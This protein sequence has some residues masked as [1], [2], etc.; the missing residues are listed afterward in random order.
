MSGEMRGVH[1]G[2]MGSQGGA[3][4]VGQGWTG[5][6]QLQLTPREGANA[7]PPPHAAPSPPAVPER[8]KTPPYIHW[9]TLPWPLSSP[10]AMDLFPT[11]SYISLLPSSLSPVF[12]SLHRPL[13]PTPAACP[14][15]PPGVCLSSLADRRMTESMYRY[16]W[17]PPRPDSHVYHHRCGMMCGEE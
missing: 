8:M 2:N 3:G 12:P 6:A 10:T 17:M 13:L 7:A 5:H 4:L 14:S 16:T 9:A 11:S 1:G 15:S